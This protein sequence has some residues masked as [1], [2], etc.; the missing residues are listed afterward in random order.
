MSGFDLGRTL[1]VVREQ[2]KL[3]KSAAARELDVSRL[4]YDMWERGAWTP[5][6]DKVGRLSEWTG[7]AR[8]VMFSVLA[9]MNGY[10]A[11]DVDLEF[12]RRADV[13]KG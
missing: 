11:E 7:V 4:T 6:L 8:E 2:K 10:I 1:E 12:V 9:R 5:D 3:S 13:N